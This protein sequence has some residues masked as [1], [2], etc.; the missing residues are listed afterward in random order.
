M[1][2][3]EI[4]PTDALATNA[5]AASKTPARVITCPLCQ[6]AAI[7]FAEQ[8]PDL[9]RIGC[10]TCGVYVITNGVRMALRFATDK[11]RADLSAEARAYHDREEMLTLVRLHD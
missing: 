9:W 7:P 1:P 5:L 2:N 6:L 11:M 4:S 10:T 8:S 3:P